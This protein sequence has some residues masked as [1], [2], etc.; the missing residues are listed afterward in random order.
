[1][2]TKYFEERKA[3]GWARDRRQ[4]SAGDA[5]NL[6]RGETQFFTSRRRQPSLSVRQDGA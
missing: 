4:N 1:M 6:A 5:Y 3:L 2:L